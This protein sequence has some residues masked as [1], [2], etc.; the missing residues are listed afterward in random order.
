MRFDD[1]RDAV[2]VLDKKPAECAFWP[3]NEFDIIFPDSVGLRFEHPKHVP[4]VFAAPLDIEGKIRL[5]DPDAH[6]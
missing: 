4:P 1:R 2:N 3:D 5:R 6:R